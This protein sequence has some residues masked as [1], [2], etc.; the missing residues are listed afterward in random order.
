MNAVDSASTAWRPTRRRA[1]AGLAA[2]VG[3]LAVPL[4][5][6]CDASTEPAADTSASLSPSPSPS[7]SAPGSASAGAAP[8][9]M[10]LFT[11]P[12]VNFQA[13]F[14]LGGAGQ[15]SSDVGEVL[16]AVNTI[17]KAGLSSQTYTD[18]FNSWGDR[19]IS[20]ATN[21]GGKGQKETQRFRALRASSY[22]EQALY[23]VLGTRNPDNEKSVYLA[24]RQAW[25]IF[26]KNCSP[27]A[28]LTTVPYGRTALPVWFFRPD[29][30]AKRRPTLILT[31]GSDG[32]NTDMWTYGVAA[33]LQ[34]GWNAV[35]YD[36]PGQ[37][38]VLFV[39]EVPMTTRWENVVRP[40]VDFLVK[41]DD[42]DSE[43]VAISGFSLG[44]A[45]APRAAA[46][47]NRLAAVVAAPGCLSL[48]AAFPPEI[49]KVLAPTKA[50]TNDIWNKDVV[51]HL[52][53]SDR[54]TLNKRFEPYDP[55][56]M[57]AARRGKVFTDFWTPARVVIG[58]DITDVVPRIKAPTLV[59]DFEADQ[60]FPGQAK[61]MYG[62]LRGPKTYVELTSAQGA[63]LHC[64]PMAPQYYCE[65]VFDWLDRTLHA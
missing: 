2:G 25:D 54:F 49:R 64:S 55:A 7:G 24:F 17:N 35:V 61:T 48:W 58:L 38:E 12:D 40:I 47:D 60:F 30:S 50:E 56:V 44:G 33:A 65:V 51:P 39:N 26:A 21:A 8:G 15:H 6:G 36:G 37:G 53:A 4:V 13:L 20:Q 52:T 45:L 9:V 31:N 43:R 32:Q 14:A 46:F 1:L 18:T 5:S 29:A 22:Y 41:R 23:F 16:T 62:L 28:V 10:E 59:I 27:P 19:L 42:V 63:Q 57:R 3:A 11:N 34:R